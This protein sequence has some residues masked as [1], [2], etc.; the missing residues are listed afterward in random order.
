[1]PPEAI[2]ENCNKS[3]AVKWPRNPNRYCSDSCRLEALHKSNSGDSNFNWKPK[4]TKTCQ[5][6]GNSFQAMPWNADKRIWC[7]AKCTNEAR[8]NTTGPDHPLY[9]AKTPMQCEVCGS[10][11]LVKPSLVHRFRACS[12]RCA[13]IIKLKENPRISSRELQVKSALDELGESYEQQKVIH[14]F[15]VDFYLPSRNLVIECDG[16]YW[17]S[18]PR[19]QRVSREKDD[20]FAS[21]E[22]PIARLREEIIKTGA[23]K[24]VRETLALYPV[25]IP[26]PMASSGLE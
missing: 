8:R 9:K 6:C 15:I 23:L 11:R 22:I 7:S 10:T 18:L 17:H 2:C 20:Y 14:H 21:A 5:W 3:F 13:A 12:R 26:V 16:S 25:T 4:I 19:S 1:M 24:A